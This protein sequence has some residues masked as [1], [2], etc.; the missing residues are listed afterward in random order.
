MS[1]AT[2]SGPGG[3]APKDVAHA[4]GRECSKPIRLTERQSQLLAGL[5]ADGSFVQRG[6]WGYS[7]RMALIQLGLVIQ[8]RAPGGVGF[9]YS[10]VL[11]AEAPAR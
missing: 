10:R 6:A 11:A 5:P 8:R 9:E 7:S 3:Q 1:A 4:A 2:S